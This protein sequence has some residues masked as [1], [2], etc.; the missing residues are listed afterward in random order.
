MVLHVGFHMTPT[1]SSTSRSQRWYA[2]DSADHEAALA[3]HR[4]LTA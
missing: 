2:L 4:D 3:A 1:M